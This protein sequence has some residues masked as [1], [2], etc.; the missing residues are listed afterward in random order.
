M[1]Q[2]TAKKYLPYI[3]AAADGKSVQ[4]HDGDEWGDCNDQYPIT[5]SRP[6]C[7]RLKPGPQFRPWTAEEA[8]KHIGAVVRYIRP[9]SGNIGVVAMILGVCPNQGIRTASDWFT[10]QTAFEELECC[11]CAQATFKPCGVQ[12]GEAL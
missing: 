5:G 12:I 2:E 1:N 8:V 11:S 7:L 10:F 9:K 3:Q 6:E 4:W